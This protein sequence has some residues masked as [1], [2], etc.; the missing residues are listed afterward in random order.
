M[1][2]A[3]RDGLV[4]VEE[5]VFAH[6]GFENDNYIDGAAIHLDRTTA[7]ITN[8]RFDRVR[9]YGMGGAIWVGPGSVAT[10]R[11]LRLYDCSAGTGGAV[12]VDERG[13][14]QVSDCVFDHN[15]A[16]RGGALNVLRTGAA[17]ISNCV[18]TRNGARYGG[19]IYA[20]GDLTIEATTIVQNNAYDGGGISLGAGAT[21]MSRS[22][23]RNNCSEMPG[24]PD[25]LRVWSGSLRAACCALDS[26]G[27]ISAVP[28]D[29]AGQQVWDDPRFC[30]P[31]ACSIFIGPLGD[32]TLSTS[33]PCAA[34]WSP[35]GERIG[36]F[37]VVCGPGGL[38][39]CC[40]EGTC[41]LS[42]AED[43]PSQ[44]G[45]FLGEGVPCVD[46][47]CTPIPTR[48]TTWGTVKRLFR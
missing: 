21:A 12:C 26:L 24:A 28:I 18:F 16:G 4:E 39:G 19:A 38:G 2:Y 46:Q 29:F 42:T 43:C 9:A 37:D 15:A 25:D 8:C 33:S 5:C 13:A 30:D 11:S 34:E 7:F 1:I 22:I 31:V 3:E 44:G 41:I 27:M 32:Y 23:A 36:A 10:L 40:L 35:C 14:A 45:W 20:S 48:S 47:G 17:R 6:V